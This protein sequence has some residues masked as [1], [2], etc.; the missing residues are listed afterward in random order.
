MN[1]E[2]E[3]KNILNNSYK[4]YEVDSK[5]CNLEIFE[6]VTPETIIGCNY[7]DGRC[8]NSGLT[9]QVASMFYNPM[10]NSMLVLV[11]ADENGYTDKN[12]I[13]IPYIP[14]LYLG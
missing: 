2:R 8:V 3:N 5:N 12:E 4:K 1:K 13:E 7:A 11:V 14:G 6:R 10:H 9:G